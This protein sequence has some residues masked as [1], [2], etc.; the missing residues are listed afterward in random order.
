MG[1]P[2]SEAN[3]TWQIDTDR[4]QKEDGTEGKTLVSV[5]VFRR[6]DSMVMCLS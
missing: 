4:S 5:S 3:L 6:G 2:I 1:K